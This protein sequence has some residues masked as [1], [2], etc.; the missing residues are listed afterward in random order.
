M[1]DDDNPLPTWLEGDSLAPFRT[2]KET[3]AAAAL[4]LAKV[5]A[6]DV[7]FD[8]GCGDARVLT[9]AARPPFGAR[10]VGVEIEED[11]AALAQQRVIDTKTGDRVKIIHGDAL[12]CDLSG[13]GTAKG[14]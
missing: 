5:T 3:T 2:C 10:G 14:H 8:L 4:Q 9:E 11:V 1:S 7:V 6:D 12:T 13:A